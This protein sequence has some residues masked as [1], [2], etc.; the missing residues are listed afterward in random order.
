MR[1]TVAQLKFDMIWIA[2]GLQVKVNL[3]LL[4]IISF[5]CLYTC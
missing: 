2:L 3:R 4:D 5:L 1:E